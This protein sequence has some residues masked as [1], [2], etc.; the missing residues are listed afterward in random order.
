M[1]NLGKA[2]NLRTSI[3]TTWREARLGLWVAGD[4]VHLVRKLEFYMGYVADL[5]GPWLLCSVLHG[6]LLMDPFIHFLDL[7]FLPM[8]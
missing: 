1:V 8:M 7:F 6:E 3:V 4:V 2:H 5:A